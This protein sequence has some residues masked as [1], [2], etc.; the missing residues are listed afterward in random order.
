MPD[1][2]ASADLIHRARQ[3]YGDL[4]AD[5]LIWPPGLG[6]DV[7]LIG[8]GVVQYDPNGQRYVV[9]QLSGSTK[10]GRRIAAICGM[11]RRLLRRL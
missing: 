7:H 3:D 10:V 2:G 6:I 8:G 4:I 5:I 1:T 11:V 9:D